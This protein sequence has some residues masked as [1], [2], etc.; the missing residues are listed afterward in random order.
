MDRGRY[1]GP[2]GWMNAHGDG[3]FGIALRSAA[4]EPQPD[5]TGRVRLFAGCGIVAESDPK[6]ELAE[7]QAKFVPVRDALTCR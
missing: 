5:G 2:V 6:A 4:Y 1:A 7:A 3:E